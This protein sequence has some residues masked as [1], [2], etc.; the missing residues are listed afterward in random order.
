MDKQEQAVAVYRPSI[1][2]K[3]MGNNISYE[4]AIDRQNPDRHLQ[5]QLQYVA[6]EVYSYLYQQLAN[7]TDT[8]TDPKVQLERLIDKT[9]INRTYMTAQSTDHATLWY[10]QHTYELSE[11]INNNISND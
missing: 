11:L 5:S 9:V 8:D 7:S 4:Y 2:G 6:K 10:R 3:P 1:N